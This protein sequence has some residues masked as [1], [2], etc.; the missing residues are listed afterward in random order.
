MISQLLHE[1]QTH[2]SVTHCPMPLRTT[3][4]EVSAHG[5]ETVVVE[6]GQEVPGKA[7]RA[8]RFAGVEERSQVAIV[9]G[10]VV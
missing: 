2:L 8:Q 5:F 6:I 1:S 7:H 3:Q 10:C 4:T 9:E